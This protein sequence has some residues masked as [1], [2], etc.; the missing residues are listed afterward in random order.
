M[1]AMSARGSRC[2]DFAYYVAKS[3]DLPA[4]PNEALWNHFAHHGQFEGRPFR[5]AHSPLMPVPRVL[6]L[7]VAQLQQASAARPLWDEDMDMWLAVCLSDLVVVDC[8]MHTATYV[9]AC[10]GASTVWYKLSMLQVPK[11]DLAH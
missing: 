2:F 8:M 5:W 6:Q 9:L 3:H 1:L 11:C 4:L 7:Q 10:R